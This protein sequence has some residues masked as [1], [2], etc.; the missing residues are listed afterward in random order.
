[1]LSNKFQEAISNYE[2]GKY[3]LALSLFKE[4]TIEDKNNE[5]AHY[6]IC[7]IHYRLKKWSKCKNCSISFLKKF[8]KRSNILELLGDVYLF[9]GNFK[10]ARK[11]YILAKKHCSIQKKDKLR[12]KIQKVHNIAIEKKFQPKLAVIV[13]EGTDNFTDDLIEQLSER[14]WVKKFVIK[15]FK[16][17]LIRA[18]YILKNKRYISNDYFYKFILQFLGTELKKA[19]LWADI[20]WGE[21][22]DVLAAACSY[23]KPRNKKLFI[24]LHRYEAFTEI[25]FIIN[26]KKVDGLVFVSKF[27]KDI[28]EMRGL[29]LD[30]I[31]W[32]VIYNGVDL[33]RFRF[34]S[35]QKGY[36]IAWLAHII[37]RKNLLMALEIIRKLVGI[38]L[39][40]KL[41]VAGVFHDFEYEISIK[42]A[43]K[44]MHLEENVIFH[45]WIDDVNTFLEDKNYLLSTSIHESFGYNIVEAMARGIKPVIYNFYN[46]SELY[47]EEFLF[48]TVDEAV[49]KILDEKYDSESYRQYLE[50]KGWTVE[51]QVKEFESFIRDLL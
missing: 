6:Y 42:N 36:N 13:A 16:T 48:N 24:R 8:G 27:M 20:T 14:Y 51:H 34:K 46:A 35:R 40:Y 49:E 28:L 44:N 43:I 29:K 41:H 12:E 26:W 17:S 15:S 21:W 32:K 45:G 18:L 50:K 39:N 37:P 23:I 9:E 22:V 31:N 25:P 30:D 7:L 1:L 10:K 38:D 3:N 19:M 2:K 33:E 11:C 47:E 5:D 4:I